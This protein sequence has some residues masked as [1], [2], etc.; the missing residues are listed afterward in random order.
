MSI[1]LHNLKQALKAG[2]PALHQVTIL[3]QHPSTFLGE[4]VHGVDGSHGVVV[5]LLY[6]CISESSKAKDEIASGCT[7]NYLYQVG[8]YDN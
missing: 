5:A 7:I 4:P 3:K 2:H 1:L 8:R 6:A